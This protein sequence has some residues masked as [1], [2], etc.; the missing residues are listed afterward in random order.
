M[1]APIFYCVIVVLYGDVLNSIF[2]IT[3]MIFVK[4]LPRVL[5]DGLDFITTGIIKYTGLNGDCKIPISAFEKTIFYSPEIC[6]NILNIF[7][8]GIKTT[9]TNV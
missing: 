2:R 8:G 9:K 1:V 4:Y 6:R 5:C 7:W 3:L